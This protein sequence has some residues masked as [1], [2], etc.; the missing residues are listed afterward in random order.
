MYNNSVKS[1]ILRV[2]QCRRDKKKLP[3]GI[4][5]RQF[6]YPAGWQEGG[7]RTR[8]YEFSRGGG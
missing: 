7:H 5:V 6:F 2:D 3:C 8:N 1:V 4:T